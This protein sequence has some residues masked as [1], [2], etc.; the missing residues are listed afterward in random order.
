MP[1]KKRSQLSRGVYTLDSDSDGDLIELH[2]SRYQ[3]ADYGTALSSR[4]VSATLWVL[5]GAALALTVLCDIQ[6]QLHQSC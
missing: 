1:N 4:C 6:G 3:E 2:L 5:T